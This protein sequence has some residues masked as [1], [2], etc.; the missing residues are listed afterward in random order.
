MFARLALTLALALSVPAFAADRDVTPEQRYELGERYAKRGLRTKALEQFNRVRNY[1]R[2]DPISLKAELAIAD[3]SFEADEYTEARLAYE[4]FARLHPR[5]EDLDFVVY[6]IGLCFFKTASKVAGR[7]QTTTRQAVT[8]WSGFQD[9]FP[10]STHVADVRMY[11]GKSRD[12]L[13]LKE[14]TVARFYAG[15]RAWVAARRRADRVLRDFPESRHV[16]EA[17]SL[18]GVAYHAWGL[19]LEAERT[20]ERLAAIDPAS[21]WLRKL[22]RAL[23]RPPGTPPIEETFPR[24]YRVSASAS[25]AMPGQ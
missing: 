9:R 24:P 13:A 15:R 20:R 4:D 8:A 21:P 2:D 10:E 5:H 16:A 25:P 19:D 14:L 3:M 6:R 23:A 7:D 18:S 17:L 12:R 11:L 1:H 22:D